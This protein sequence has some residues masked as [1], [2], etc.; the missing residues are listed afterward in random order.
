MDATVLPL[1]TVKLQQLTKSYVKLPG[2]AQEELEI[3]SPLSSDLTYLICP[4]F[5]SMTAAPIV[6]DTG[7]TVLSTIVIDPPGFGV[8]FNCDNL[9]V[10]D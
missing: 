1:A 6:V 10:N 3:A 9:N 4:G 5:T 8:A 2:D 7:N